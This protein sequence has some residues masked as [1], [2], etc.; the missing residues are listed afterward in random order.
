MF[1]HVFSFE[2]SKLAKGATGELD[3]KVTLFRGFEVGSDARRPN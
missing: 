3:S 2:T 1:C